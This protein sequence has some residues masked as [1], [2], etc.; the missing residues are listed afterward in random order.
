M[1]PGD[2]YPL[3]DCRTVVTQQTEHGSTHGSTPQRDAKYKGLYT[4]ERRAGTSHHSLVAAELA[5]A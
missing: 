2:L 5:A 4:L 1:Y 3:L